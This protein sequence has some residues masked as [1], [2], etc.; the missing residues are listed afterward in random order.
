MHLD[1]IEDE[2]EPDS[3]RGLPGKAFVFRHG[4]HC[5]NGPARSL[6]VTLFCSVEEKLSEVD[7]PTTCEYGAFG[8]DDA[9]LITSPLPLSP[10]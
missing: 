2:G 3:S 8:G 9:Q 5:W 7:E 6:R 1:G 10:T 4:D